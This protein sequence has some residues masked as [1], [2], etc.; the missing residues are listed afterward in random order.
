MNGGIQ[1]VQ[2]LMSQLGLTEEQGQAILL[3]M[4]QHGISA[5]DALLQLIH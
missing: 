4:S 3:L 1:E 2:L 5:Q